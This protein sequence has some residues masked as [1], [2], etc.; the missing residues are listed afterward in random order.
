MEKN[1]KHNLIRKELVLIKE[2][3]KVIGKFTVSI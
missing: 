1:I 3:S 2:D